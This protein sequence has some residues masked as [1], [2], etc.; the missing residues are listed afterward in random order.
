MQRELDTASRAALEAGERILEIY[1]ADATH[2][3]HKED[4][5]P[6]THADLA[7]NAAIVSI[8][9]EAF[10]DDHILTEEAVDDLDRLEAE[11]VWIVDPLDGTREFIK[12]NGEFTVNI[13]L[14]E[15]GRPELGVIYVPVTGELYSARRGQG[16]FV[17]SNGSAPRRLSVSPRDS[18]AEM[19][20]AKSRSHASETMMRLIETCRFADVKS[21]GSSLKGCLVAT[22]EADIYLRFG[23][24]NEW[25]ICAMHAVVVEAG[26]A[27][28][29]LEGREMTYNHRN[30]L[31]Q[32][33]IVSNNRIHGDLVEIARSVRSS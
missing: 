27:M 15:G 1:E 32:G 23:P 13:A 9:A 7:A 11:R 25:D 14:V 6:L 26:G 19:V 28:T 31:N 5:S 12:R 4:G 21:R 3:S 24:T 33:F 10:P 22:G 16:A 18:P 30:T 8:L 2:V 20:L 29:D 17:Q